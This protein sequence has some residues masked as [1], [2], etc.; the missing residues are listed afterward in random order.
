MSKIPGKNVPSRVLLFLIPNR[1]STATAAFAG[2]RTAVRT[3][4]TLF[5]AFFRVVNIP[6]RKTRD[7][8][9]DAQKNVINQRH[10]LF[11]PAEG[12]IRLD[13]LIRINAQ[14]GKN[15]SKRSHED[16]AANKT[17]TKRSRC[18]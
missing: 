5:S 12:I 7:Q 15:G 4:D 13:F 10:R 6:T 11:P 8:Q 14:I 16:Q 18:D 17:G 3:A 2:A 1:A 9:D